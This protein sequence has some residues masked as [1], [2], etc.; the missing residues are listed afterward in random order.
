MGIS[1]SVY[2]RIKDESSV[3]NGLLAKHLFMQKTR[4]MRCFIL[5]GTLFFSSTTNVYSIIKFTASVVTFD[6]TTKYDCLC[7]EVLLHII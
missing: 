4:K 1:K 7:L 3:F 6:S 2:E 5:I